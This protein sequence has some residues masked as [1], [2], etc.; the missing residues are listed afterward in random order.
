MND[1]D[2]KVG[3]RS[4]SFQGQHSFKEK[5]AKGNDSILSMIWYLIR[6]CFLDCRVNKTKEWMN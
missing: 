4:S 2:I 1:D 3:T 5:F 6:L